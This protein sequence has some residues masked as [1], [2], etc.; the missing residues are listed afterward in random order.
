MTRI[1]VCIHR[2]VVVSTCRLTVYN[3]LV[4]QKIYKYKTYLYGVKKERRWWKW[5]V[6]AKTQVV[7]LKT[8]LV[9]VGA[10]WWWW[11]YEPRIRVQ[12]FK[13]RT[14]AMRSRAFMGD[15]RKSSVTMLKIWPTPLR[16]RTSPINRTRNVHSPVPAGSI[17]PLGFNAPVLCTLLIYFFL[18]FFSLSLCYFL[19]GGGV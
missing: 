12:G 18:S 13:L 4:E 17:F 2:I 3:N 7:M 6:L 9:K 11:K 19:W 1:Q 14:M 10:T 15:A 16:I 8:W 5:V